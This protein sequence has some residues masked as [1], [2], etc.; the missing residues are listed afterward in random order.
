MFNPLKMDPIE[1]RML[2][3][4]LASSIAYYSNMYAAD[5]VP[6]PIE[7]RNR[8]DQHLPRNSELIG[9]IAPPAALY[10]AKKVVKNPGTKEKLDD[11]F[12]GSA[13][14]SVPNLMHD[15]VVQTAY[16]VGVDTRPP[17]KLPTLAS[18]RSTYTVNSTRPTPA[19]PAT[20]GMSKYA[21]TV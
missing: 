21:L 17:A 2:I 11:M 10:I 14:Y 12:L 13:L 9:N 1:K 7:L 6:Y 15:V 20:S 16:Q 18:A 8:L 5:A 4:G 3:G 19:R